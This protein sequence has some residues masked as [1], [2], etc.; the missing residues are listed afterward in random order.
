M[1][2]MRGPDA[3]KGHPVIPVV[4]ELTSQAFRQPDIPKI[5]RLAA[6]FGARAGMGTTQMADFVQAVSEAAA[7]AFAQGPCTAR[8]RLWAAGARAFCEISGDGMLVTDGPWQPRQGD[9]EKLRR[10][11]LRRL[12]DHVSVESGPDGVTVRLA[13]T[14]A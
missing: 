2:R 12:C 1:M 3:S 7:C 9:A 13:M 6:V 4:R 5:R 14:V 10:W 11:L 8:M